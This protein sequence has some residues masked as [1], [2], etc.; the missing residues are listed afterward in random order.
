MVS[1]EQYKRL[2]WSSRR[3]MLELDLMLVPFVEH[4]FPQ[5]DEHKQQQYIRLLTCEDMDLF[6]WL[7]DRQP[8]DDLE[9][10]AIVRLILDF[11]AQRA[12]EHRTS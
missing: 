7:L 12:T 6:T 1:T 2:I 4:C 3:G 8:P 10:K 9:L 5:L 11:A